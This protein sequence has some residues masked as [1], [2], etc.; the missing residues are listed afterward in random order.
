MNLCLSDQPE[1]LGKLH[2]RPPEIVE[3]HGVRLAKFVQLP[4][5]VAC[6]KGTGERG[7]GCWVDVYEMIL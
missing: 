4:Q 6:R 2:I 3:A 5:R 7:R 1:T